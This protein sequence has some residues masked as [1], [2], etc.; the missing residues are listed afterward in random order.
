MRLP[1]ATGSMFVKLSQT[2]P[3]TTLLNVWKRRQALPVTAGGLA[4]QKISGETAGKN[5]GVGRWA[6]YIFY[7]GCS[8]AGDF[9]EMFHF[10]LKSNSAEPSEAYPVS[11][12]LCFAA[13]YDI[14]D[15]FSYAR[16][17]NQAETSIKAQ[18][19][20][21]EQVIQ[22]TKV[23]VTDY[24]SDGTATEREIDVREMYN[25]IDSNLQENTTRIGDISSKVE[26]N[27]GNV[28]SIEGKLTTITDSVDKVTTQI[29]DF[30]KAIDDKISSSMATYTMSSSAWMAKF[31][32][33]R[34][35]RMK[36]ATSQAR[37]SEK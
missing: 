24:G 4:K 2:S 15:T 10:C 29:A 3:L 20:R 22:S 11:W 30:P 8:D 31:Q 18:N 34:I 6:E 27:T 7:V 5:I 14:T 1:D 35:R 26:E 9:G 37:R 17:L 28:L 23:T 13:V 21:I 16:K 12:K 33:A 19:D 32:K 36:T 25:R